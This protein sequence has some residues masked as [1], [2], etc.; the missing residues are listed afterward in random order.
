MK[1]VVGA[2]DT[3][4]RLGSGEVEVLATPRLIAWMEAATVEAA[5]PGLEPGETTVGTAV[6]VRHRRPTPPGGIVEV[7]ADRPV[8]DGGRLTF[9][10]RAVDG[11]GVVVGDGE[12]DRVA[13]DREGFAPPRER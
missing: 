11:D 8:R 1:H 2:D 12:I 6:R 10:V 9:T 13:V 3:A 7:T 5:R 4:V